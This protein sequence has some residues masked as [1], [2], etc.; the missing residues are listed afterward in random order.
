M[1]FLLQPATAWTPG[2][3]RNYSH[4]PT[5]DFPKREA[6]EIDYDWQV[7]DGTLFKDTFNYAVLHGETKLIIWQQ[8]SDRLWNDPYVSQCELIP[9][10]GIQNLIKLHLYFG[11]RLSDYVYINIETS[12]Y[13]SC[14]DNTMHD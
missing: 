14:Y 13:R 4:R 7:S 6:A 11:I 5:S 10:T 2:G 9:E 8:C 3:D 12:D 1:G